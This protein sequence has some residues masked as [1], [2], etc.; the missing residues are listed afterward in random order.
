MTASCRDAF[1]R[2]FLPLA[3]L[4]LTFYCPVLSADFEA[5]QLAL[6]EG[7][8]ATALAE[9]RQDAGQGHAEALL[10]LGRLYE[11]GLG[12]PRDAHTALVLYRVAYL[13][14][15]KQAENAVN[16]IANTTAGGDLARAMQH[17]AQ[18][19]Q[20]GRYLPP[21]PG[22]PAAP[23]APAPVVPATQ[24]KPPALPPSPS[25][26]ASPSAT[27][28]ATGPQPV[29]AAPAI[30]LAGRTHRLKYACSMQFKYQDRGSGGRQDLA[31]FQPS[32]EPGYFALGGYAQNNYDQANGC[33][34]TLKSPAGATNALLAPPAS[35]ERVW[36]DKGTG[37]MMDGSIW[38][39]VPASHDYVCLGHV[40]QSG[41]DPPAVEGY[42][43]VHRC[44][45]HAVKPTN[46]LWSTEGTG[47]RTPLAVYI[48]PHI[49]SFIAVPAGQAPAEMLD[50]NLEAECLWK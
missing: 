6:E 49:N 7:D 44:M 41:Y 24:S 18:L 38:R 3:I 12:V 50:L 2:G 10:Q 45:V 23:V 20:E 33:S 8:Y 26:T 5:G 48:L 43:C 11:K 19:Q 15:N 37:S 34:L 1:T 14:G 36:K 30:Q 22:S 25:A 28:V 35:W 40:G 13:Q 39:A 16:R 32:P 46:P 47:A 29:A 42:A 9:W 31:L 17:A 27:I 21:L 4:Y